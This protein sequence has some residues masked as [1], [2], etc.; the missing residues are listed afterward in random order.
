MVMVPV[1]LSI[2]ALIEARSSDIRNLGRFLIKHGILLETEPPQALIKKFLDSSMPD[3]SYLRELLRELVS[4]RTVPGIPQLR[5]W[6][7]SKGEDKSTVWQLIA[8]ICSHDEIRES[9]Q[10]L[11]SSGVLE[12]GRWRAGEISDLYSMELSTFS[13]DVSTGEIA[14][15]DGREVFGK[16]IL[17]PLKS[18]AKEVRILDNYFHQKLLESRVDGGSRWLLD[19]FL[20][21]ESGLSRRVRVYSTAMYDQMGPEG[22]PARG[23]WVRQTSSLYGEIFERNAGN[24]G[25][26]LDVYILPE[27]HG[28]N[29]N[30]QRR[31]QF[32]ISDR[33]WTSVSCDDSADL[34]DLHSSRPP[35]NWTLDSKTD[36]NKRFSDI[37]KIWQ[38]HDFVEAFRFPNERMPLP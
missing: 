19:T 10:H 26:Q 38:Q 15:T 25:C 13:A 22:S 18:V 8:V 35:G 5:D 7:L 1:A 29:L 37:S 17:R 20:E 4:R 3:K 33:T 28:L 12:C 16:K 34:F 14:G 36:V 24:E 23:D 30:H 9:G 6:D 11:P 27:R 21:V 32:A 31:M 2:D